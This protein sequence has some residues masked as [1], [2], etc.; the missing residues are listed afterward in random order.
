[1]CNMA[2]MA[3]ILSVNEVKKLFLKIKLIYLTQKLQNHYFNSFVQC[4]LL[5]LERRMNFYLQP[6]QKK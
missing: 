3:V 5:K 6:L 4:I 1:M 2:H